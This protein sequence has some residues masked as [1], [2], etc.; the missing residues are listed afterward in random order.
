MYLYSTCFFA[1]SGTLVVS[2]YSRKSLT[3]RHFS[4]KA[5]M[6]KGF[7]PNSLGPTAILGLLQGQSGAINCFEDHTDR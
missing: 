6:R 1:S 4:Q 5:I 3:F 2:M 7:I